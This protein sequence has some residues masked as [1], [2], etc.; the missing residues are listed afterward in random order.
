MRLA[1]LRDEFHVL[2]TVHRG[3]LALNKNKQDEI[4]FLNL[5]E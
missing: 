3:I 1:K 5:F 4:L 2:W